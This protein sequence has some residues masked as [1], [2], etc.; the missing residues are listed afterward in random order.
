MFS[1]QPLHAYYRLDGNRRRLRRARHSHSQCR[2][3]KEAD[4]AIAPAI[5][6]KTGRFVGLAA[7]GNDT[8]AIMRAPTHLSRLVRGHF[9][10]FC[11]IARKDSAVVR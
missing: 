7:P 4:A 5:A 10:A 2:S 8:E 9:L 1:I 11:V 6:N 3:A